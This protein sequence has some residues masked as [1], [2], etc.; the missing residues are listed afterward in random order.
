MNIGTTGGCA[1]KRK[2]TREDAGSVVMFM[3]RK[4]IIDLTGKKFGKLT[5]IREVDPSKG[6]RMWLCRCECGTEK[7]V[8]QHNLTQGLSTTCGCGKHL[9]RSAESFERVDGVSIVH[10]KQKIRSNNSTGHKGV[11]KYEKDGRVYYRAQLQVA[12][13]FFS[14]NVIT[15]SSVSLSKVF[16]HIF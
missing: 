2:N 8:L 9:F 7:A 10:L 14:L 13:K 15:V 6:G 1:S 12:G 16:L 4:K 3:A 5:V 11:T